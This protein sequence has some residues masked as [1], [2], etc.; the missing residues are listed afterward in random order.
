LDENGPV[1]AQSYKMVYV[2]TKEVNAKELQPEQT[3]KAELAIPDVLNGPV[4][5]IVSCEWPSFISPNIATASTRVYCYL[6]LHF[7][8]WPHI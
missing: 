6:I 2:D 3:E 5:S 1:V 4:C 7:G 8:H